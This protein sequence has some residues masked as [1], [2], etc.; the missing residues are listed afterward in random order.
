MAQSII[1]GKTYEWIDP[2]TGKPSPAG[3]GN[4]KLV[5]NTTAPAAGAAPIVPSNLNTTPLGAGGVQAL[6]KQYYGRAAT[7]EELNY[8]SQKSDAQLRPKL[9]PNSATELARNKV[10]PDAKGTTSPTDG[11]TAE[12]DG[13]L[14][15][16]QKAELD[17]LNKDIDSGNYSD[18]EKAILKQ[19]AGMDF[20]SGNHVPTA[21]ELAKIVNTATTNATESLNPYYTEQ[22][23][24]ELEDLKNKMEDIRTSTANYVASETAGYKKTLADTKASLRSR[25]LTFSGSATAQLGNEAGTTNPN[26]IEGA[27][28]EGR[29]L[30]YATKLQ[31]QAEL[32]RTAGITGERSLGSAA[33][34]S[35]DVATP[36][37][38]TNLYNPK[39]LGQEGNIPTGD[40]AL[41]RLKAIEERKNLNLSKTR[42]YI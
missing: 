5:E 22:T 39:A 36:Y 17:K 31:T 42:L 8:W 37:G 6:F 34:G 33:V 40:I 4:P 32:A 16:A 19:I 23:R 14:T 9:I 41:D 30:D 2:A 38:N 11:G 21:D 20:T 18:A 27:I 13:G 15:A 28:P 1:N 26:N 10:K 35:L 24:R 12:S 25:G 7:Q 3:V 29:R